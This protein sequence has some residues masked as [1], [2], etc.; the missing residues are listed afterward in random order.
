MLAPF[1]YM[2]HVLKKS[3]VFYTLLYIFLYCSIETSQA[4]TDVK[5]VWIAIHKK[6]RTENQIL[7][8][9]V[10]Q[11]PMKRVTINAIAQNDP[12]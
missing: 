4:M 12:A 6:S 3:I 2:K 11:V 9:R 10:W 1:T 5:E 7:C 8:V